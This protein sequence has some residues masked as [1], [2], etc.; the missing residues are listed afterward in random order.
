MA[1]RR[2]EPRDPDAHRAAPEV[3]DHRRRLTAAG[4]ETEVEERERDTVLAR[5]QHEPGAEAEGRLDRVGVEDLERK[6]GA[7]PADPQ[8]Q[9]ASEQRGAVELDPRPQRGRLAVPGQ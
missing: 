1:S 9:V 2:S 3:L 6:R 8:R 7:M 5:E 4:L